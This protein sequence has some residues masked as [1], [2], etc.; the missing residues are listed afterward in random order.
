MTLDDSERAQAGEARRLRR[1]SRSAPSSPPSAT[2]SAS[3][4]RS[5]PASSAASTA[6]CPSSADGRPIRGLLQTDTAVNPGNSGGALINLNGEVIGINTAI[7]NPNG[8]GFA[9][10]A[11]AVPINTPKR[12]L[13]QLVAGETID[14]PRLG[15]SGR[16]LTPSQ[17]ED[18][19]VPYGVAVLSVENGQRGG[20]GWPGVVG[21]RR[22][23]RHRRDRRPADERRSRT[24]RTTSTRKNVGDE[25]TLKVHR[26][27]EDIELTATLESWDSSA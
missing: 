22:R 10:V 6:R 20:R 16:S 12:F 11:Y 7:E 2:R 13:T 17:A 26:D 14:H 9:G 21:E 24:W 8:A 3:T 19:G 27:G 15:I 25:V 1:A 4:A 23:R 18:L 5:R